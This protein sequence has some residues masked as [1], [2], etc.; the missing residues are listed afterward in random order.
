MTLTSHPGPGWWCPGSSCPPDTAAEAPGALAW[1]LRLESRHWHAGHLSSWID[2][3]W[4]WTWG[5]LWS[6]PGT[7]SPGPRTSV[8]DWTAS[9]S[10]VRSGP[11]WHRAGRRSATTSGSWTWTS[12]L[13]LTIVGSS[14]PPRRLT[15]SCCLTGSTGCYRGSGHWTRASMRPSCRAGSSAGSLGSSR[16]RCSSSRRAAWAWAWRRWGWRARWRCRHQSWCASWWRRASR[17]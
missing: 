10:R 14:W 4:Y 7:Q 3:S 13:R 1:H 5:P 17:W 16:P 11:S 12:C 9:S 8:G 6:C 15:M 2:Y